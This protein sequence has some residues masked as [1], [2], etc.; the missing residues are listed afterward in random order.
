MAKV[1]FKYYLRDDSSSSERAEFILE[2]IGGAPDVPTDED[3]FAQLIGRPFHE[4]RLDCT[5]DT[6][7][8]K[9]EVV[10]V[11]L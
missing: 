8:H 9:V 10:E 2:E 4:V 3:E 11:T 5:Y 1:P 7:T 6:E